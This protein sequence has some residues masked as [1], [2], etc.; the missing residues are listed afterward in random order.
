MAKGNLSRY[1]KSKGKEVD[2]LMGP[3]TFTTSFSSFQ[4]ALLC[5]WEGTCSELGKAATLQ[6]DAWES[7]APPPALILPKSGE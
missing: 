4:A 1:H 3:V 2:L 5:V 7:R 6:K